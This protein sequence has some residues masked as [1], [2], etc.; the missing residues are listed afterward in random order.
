MPFDASSAA[1]I[2]DTALRESRQRPP[3]ATPKSYDAAVKVFGNSSSVSY[4]L[5]DGIPDG[6][7]AQWRGNCRTA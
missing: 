2:D 5:D 7:A 3:G 6:R 4:N 1:G